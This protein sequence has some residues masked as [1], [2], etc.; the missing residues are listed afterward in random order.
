MFQFPVSYW[1][2]D[3]PRF[4]IKRDQAWLTINMSKFTLLWWNSNSP[5]WRSTQGYKAI[6]IMILLFD[7][8]QIL[9]NFSTCLSQGFVYVIF[10]AWCNVLILFLIMI[11]PHKTCIWNGH[12]QI[13]Y[14]SCQINKS[15]NW[16]TNQ[17]IKQNAFGKS[18]KMSWVIFLQWTSV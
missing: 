12:L 11:S 17:W 6:C 13:V 2:K 4:A 7:T 5:F 1:T 9:T 3:P 16:W 18:L 8:A 10:L 15:M 14:S